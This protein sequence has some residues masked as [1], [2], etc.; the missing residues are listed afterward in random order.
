GL[1]ALSFNCLTVFLGYNLLRRCLGLKLTV[2]C[3]AVALFANNFGFLV[4][5]HNQLT[6]LMA[7]WAICLMQKGLLQGKNRFLLFAGIVLGVNIFTRIP[8]LTL[9]GFVGVVPLYFWGKEWFKNSV[10]PIL[11]FAFGNI[12]GI[13]LVFLILASLGQVE[14]MFGALES[15]F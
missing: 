5:Y 12:L 15:L 11:Y 9:L 1:L 4:F 6:A 8:N 14:I 3:L 7:L 13:G 10:F 2:I